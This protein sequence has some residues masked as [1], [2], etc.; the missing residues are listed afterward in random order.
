MARFLAKKRECL[1]ST[2][3]LKFNSSIIHL[4]NDSNSSIT[5]TQ[6]WQCKNLKLVRGE[7]AT[8]TSSRGTIRQNL[9][10]KDQYIAQRAKGAY[11]AL[12]CQPEAAYDLLVAA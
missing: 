11:I 8:T 10:T 5:L 2:R 12:V 1:T 4:E 6:E 9:T 3:N 7:N